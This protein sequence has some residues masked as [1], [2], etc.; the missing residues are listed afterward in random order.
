MY[1]Y[2]IYRWNHI[3]FE[4]FARQQQNNQTSNKRS[5][6]TINAYNGSVLIDLSLLLSKFDVSIGDSIPQ[7]LNKTDYGHFFGSYFSVRSIVC[8]QHIS[9]FTQ[10]LTIN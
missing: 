8:R 5:N 7:Y 9:R 4:S 1:T 2:S 6:I 10:K 3:N